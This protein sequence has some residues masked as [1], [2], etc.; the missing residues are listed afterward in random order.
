[1]SYTELA[2]ELNRILDDRRRIS[3]SRSGLLP[4]KGH[5]TEHRRLT[6]AAEEIRKQ[7]RRARYGTEG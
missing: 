7:M 6:Q 5:E 2:E 1:M 4:E 3:T